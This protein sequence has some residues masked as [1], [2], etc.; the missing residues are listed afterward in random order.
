VTKIAHIVNPVLFA[1]NSP[2]DF[3]Q[4]IVF[5]SMESAHVYTDKD[6]EIEF[7]SVQYPE[8]HPVIPDFFN[9]ILDL[10]RSILNIGDFNNPRKLPLIKD[11][12]DLA[13]EAT[14]AEYVIYTNIDICLMPYFYQAVNK[15]ISEGFDA[16]TINRRTISTEHEHVDSLPLMYAE[17]GEPHRGWDCFVFKRAL[18][19]KFHLGNLCL[20][21]PLVGLAVIANMLAFAENFNQITRSHLTFHIGND[22]AWH[23]R[24]NTDYDLHNRSELIKILRSLDEI[25]GGFDEKS[26]P[27]I[28]LRFHK[29]KII[30]YFY[31]NLLMRFYIPAKYTRSIRRKRF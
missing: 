23:A 5:K 6:L 4:Q 16:F 19:P 7:I 13:V 10:N 11:I 1:K 3:A 2:H 14:D 31:D 8:D 9:V 18:Y 20:G 17:I 24:S 21:I 12:F 26:P 30:S 15:L 29:N 28:Y 22:R 27:G 25:I